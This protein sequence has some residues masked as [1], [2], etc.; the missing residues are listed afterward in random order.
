MVQNW[1]DAVRVSEETVNVRKQPGAGAIFSAV[2]DGVEQGRISEEADGSFLELWNHGSLG[3]EVLTL[4]NTT[5]RACGQSWA[6]GHGEG[7]KVGALALVRA[8]HNVTV[9][10]GEGEVWSF[11]L[12][13]SNQFHVTSRK[14]LNQ[15]PGIVRVRVSGA[16]IDPIFAPSDYLFFSAAASAGIFES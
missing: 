4:G 15:Q 14:E 16:P 7:L 5:K 6:G 2:G 3:R 8:G 11:Q 10:S 12:D 1:W 13:D 9:E